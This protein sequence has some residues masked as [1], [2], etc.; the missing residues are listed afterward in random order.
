MSSTITRVAVL[1]AGTMGAGIAAHCANVGLQ[2]YLL[3]IAP[4][5]LTPEEERR[6]LKLESPAVRNRIVKAGYDRMAKSR[7]ASLA[8][9]AAGNLITVGNFADNFDWVREADWIVEVIVER[10][11]PK[12]ALMARI[13]EYRKPGS[14]VSSNT[15]GIPLNQIA[16][17]RGE[18]FKRHFL[19]T[20]FFNPPRYLKLLEVIPIAETDPAVVRQVKGFGENVLG[21]GVVICKDTPNFIANRFGSFD[22]MYGARW[23]LDNGYTIEEVDALTGPLIGRPNTASFRLADLAGIDI[24]AGVAD[25]LYAAAP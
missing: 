9:A 17:G 18:D 13:E 20:H 4:E 21:K 12:Q 3:D 5:T 24:M 23:A 2:V 19:G 25:N 15:S 14:I 16:E 10:V 1:G 22:G 6:G 11:G 7:P 8:N